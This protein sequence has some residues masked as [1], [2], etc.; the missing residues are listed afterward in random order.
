[1]CCFCLQRQFRTA[2]PVLSINKLDGS[3]WQTRN[4]GKTGNPEYSHFL[5]ITDAML[6]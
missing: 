2:I 6:D 4:T 3:F 1:V 5:E